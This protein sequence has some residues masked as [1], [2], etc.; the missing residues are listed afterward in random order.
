MDNSLLELIGGL[1]EEYDPVASLIYGSRVAGYARENSL[2]DCMAICH[3]PG[4]ARYH[5]EKFNG[6]QASILAIDEE[7]FILDVKKGALGGFVAGRMLFPY[8]GLKGLEYLKQKEVELKKEVIK[9]DIEYI[10]QQYGEASRGIIIDPNY[11]AVS[12]ISRLSKT[13]PPIRYSYL[14]TFRSDLRKKNIEKVMSGYDGAIE[15]LVNDGILH[16]ESLGIS[17]GEDFIDDIISRSTADKVVNVV[18][19][20]RKALSS[21]LMHGRVG[22]VSPELISRELASKF[23][24]EFVL[25]T[26]SPKMED[27]RIYLS[28]KTKTGLIPIDARGDI[29]EII[30]KIRPDSRIL[31]NPLGGV[32]NEVY[33]VHANGEKLVAKKFTDW[34]GFKWFTLNLVALGTKSFFVSGKARLTN[35]FGINHLLQKNFVNVPEI[36]HIS[37]SDRILIEKYVDGISVVDI[38]KKIVSKKRHEQSL[39]ESISDVG[40]NIAKVHT[41]GIQ[42]GDS[43]PEN[44]IR[45]AEGKVFI[46]DLE[47]AKKGGDFAWDIAVFLYFSAH[48]STPYGDKMK[49]L[50]E[51]FI[52]G[53]SEQGN[54]ENLRQAAGINYLKVFSFWAFPRSNYIVSKTLK[55]AT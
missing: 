54:S 1:A 48:Y 45:N 4:G 29:R 16:H 3:Y 15:Q 34:H 44:F 41:L 18:E 47:Q 13:F 8:L 31:I 5:L 28:L 10:I 30:V 35:E 42:L 7:L 53:Y 40:R 26:K 14:N 27:P 17:I 9:R 24:R 21:Y 12:Y 36:F 49:Q 32:L 55:K 37:I 11:F 22:L 25:T 23:K 38:I 46:L 50:T 39:Y 19:I 43:K 33:L 20:S 6:D 2:Y 52:H 51:S